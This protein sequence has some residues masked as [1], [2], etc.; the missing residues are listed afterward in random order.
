MTLAAGARDGHLIVIKRFGA[1][2]VTLVARIDGV[3]ANIA[4]NST[5]MREAVSLAWCQSL[6]TWLMI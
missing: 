4:M 6:N 5:T 2:T 3:T 1:G